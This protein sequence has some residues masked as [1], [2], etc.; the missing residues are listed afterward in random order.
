ML[1]V[2]LL[3]NLSLLWHEQNHA[4]TVDSVFTN[5]ELGAE[6]AIVKFRHK[7][8]HI[9]LLPYERSGLELT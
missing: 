6:Y 1:F 3:E 5:D 4:R 2:F 8:Y 7:R 9:K